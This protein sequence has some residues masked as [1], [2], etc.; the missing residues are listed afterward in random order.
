MICLTLAVLLLSTLTL[1]PGCKKTSREPQTRKA[2]FT[3]I[4]DVP[5]ITDYE[6]KA[7]E[8]LRGRGPFVFGALV[9]TEAFHNENGEIRGYAALFCEWLSEL[10]GIRIE[11]A[12]YE[13]GELIAGL[14]T[15]DIDFTGELT[16]TDERRKIYFMTDAI[17]E[18]SIKL[19]RIMGSTP[20]PEIA[21][22]RPLRYAFLEGTTTF[23]SVLAHESS[24]FETIFLDDYETA[25][26]L[27]KSGK[28]DAF[29]EEG[30]AEAA[31]D[32]YGDVFAT[33]YFPLIYGPVS[34]TTQNPDLAPVISVVQKVLEN[35]G[36]RY[37]TELYNIGHLEY[38]KHKIL[39]LFNEEENRYIHSN[40]VVKFA[41]EYDNYPISFYNT[42]EKQWQGVAHD[43][44]REIEKLTGLSF[45]IVND[46]QA[47]WPDLLRMLE[48]GEASMV[49]D[50][51]QTEKRKG[52]FLW[53]N[54]E[55]TTDYYALLSRSDHRG[56]NVNE[57]LFTKVGLIIDSAYAELFRSWFPNHSN[58]I[59]YE[60]AGLAFDALERGEI[61]MVMAS[62]HDLLIMTNY[63]DRKSV[64]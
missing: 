23:D 9:S 31:F 36:I 3:S 13:W 53:P 58:T 55:L 12:I 20:L 50:L 27:L 56:I 22:A 8:K 59:E 6:I 51:I 11:P 4:E 18:R 38:V 37:L 57:I 29:F 46:Q 62:Y 45:E 48:T 17:A 26:N 60:S 35:D 28:A 43:V 41:A 49:S 32:V 39:L 25:Y 63:R 40:P 21:A 19:M 15:R 16:A 42:H 5:G 10:L 1:L 33:D 24:A 34:L 52:L 64:V 47:E 61:E 44:L 14:E 54:A 7:I 30:S 2:L